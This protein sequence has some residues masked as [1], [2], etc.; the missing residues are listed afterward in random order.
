MSPNP[1]EV[2]NGYECPE[3]GDVAPTAW[4]ALGH[5]NDKHPAGKR[6]GE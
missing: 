1:K 3:C 4:L 6:K 5:L 2:E